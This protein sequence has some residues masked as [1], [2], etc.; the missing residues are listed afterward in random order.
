MA[1]LI[2]LLNGGGGLAI[3]KTAETESAIDSVLEID[4]QSTNITSNTTPDTATTGVGRLK[5]RDSNYNQLGYVDTRFYTD[6][7]QCIRLYCDRTINDT[8]YSNGLLLHVLAD[9]S[10]KVGFYNDDCKRAWLTA[11]TPDVLYNNTS[12]TTG[13]ITLSSSAANY[14]YLEI[15][16]VSGN[17]GYGSTRVFSPNK[18]YFTC[19]A[20][21]M[22]NSTTAQIEFCKCYINGT[23]ISRTNGG[24]ANIDTS[25]H[26]GA[27]ATNQIKITRVEGW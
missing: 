2:S 9:G 16:F 6:G 21:S 14:N 26:A 24:Y 23:A 22:A 8:W 19:V 18:K 27:T 11:L 25:D 4:L 1:P 13:A 7:S 17:A 12:G 20:S 3:G 15:Y 5:F 10:P